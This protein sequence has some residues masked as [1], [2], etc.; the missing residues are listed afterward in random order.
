MFLPGRE[1]KKDRRF[2]KLTINSFLKLSLKGEREVISS[3]TQI[4]ELDVTWE[5]ILPPLPKGR[6]ALVPSQRDGIFLLAKLHED[7]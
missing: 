2:K 5:T 6:R 1:D 4:P 3:T 7:R